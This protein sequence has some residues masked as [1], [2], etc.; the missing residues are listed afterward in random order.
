M[1]QMTHETL[2]TGLGS[3]RDSSPDYMLA[4]VG[5]ASMQDQAQ[6][7]AEYGRNGDVYIVHAAQGETVIPL[8]VFNANPKVKGLLYKQM[9]DMGLDPQ[10]YVVGNDLNSINPV[11]G[12]PEFFFK[13]IFRTVK[14]VV[15]KVIK[16]AKK[17]AP[18]AL[19]IIA[20]T[21]GFPFLGTAFKAGS[22]AASAL[23]GG[24]GTLAQGGSFKDALK[25]GL[26]AGGIASLTGGLKTL[27]TGESFMSGV[28]RSFTGAGA[29]SWQAQLGRLQE[30]ELGDFLLAR[31][32][33]PTPYVGLETQTGGFGSLTPAEMGIPPAPSVSLSGVGQNPNVV[34]QTKAGDYLSNQARARAA[35]PRQTP[36]GVQVAGGDKQSIQEAYRK[37]L[38]EARAAEQAKLEL[39]QRAKAAEQALSRGYEKSASEL[40]AAKQKDSWLPSWAQK[41]FPETVSP[42]ELVKETGMKIGDAAKLLEPGAG[43]NPGYFQQYA[44]K[45]GA[46]LGAAYLG[47]AFDA[48]EVEQPEERGPY[49]NPEWDLAR[50]EGE[51]DADYDARLKEH[52]RKYLIPDE[53]LDP[54]RFTPPPYVIPPY[55][56]QQ[57]MFGADG[58]MAAYPRRE[59]LVEGPGT[60]RSDDI[61]AMLSDGEF[62]MNSKS[63]RGADPSGRG[64]RYAGAR[65][66]YDMMRN[67]EMKG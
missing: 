25:S 61:P 43:I 6:K 11:T 63:V 53:A 27:G 57:R 45:V 12:L 39:A 33:D 5:L 58:G 29:P 42:A 54:T 51:S 56:S 22:F 20:A 35:M 52:R 24:L 46:G 17:I 32:E 36:R 50:E 18:I 10:E 2:D 13:K 48:P 28:E 38:L 30:G 47:G 59:L 41:A 19:P 60:E 14:K 26:M 64:N 67:F 65:N 21:F 8:E 15:K 1:Q 49:V 16:V 31:S 4:P 66:L 37:A 62:V 40:L 44:G 55:S 23:A 34:S 9:R 7:L 3:F